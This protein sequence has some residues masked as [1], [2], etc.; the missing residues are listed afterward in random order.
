M[1]V[2]HAPHEFPQLPRQAR[3]FAR[4]RFRP[5]PNLSHRVSSVCLTL[6]TLR[7]S[8]RIPRRCSQSTDFRVVARYNR[9]AYSWIRNRPSRNGVTIKHSNFAVSQRLFEEDLQGLSNLKGDVPEGV[10]LFSP[11]RNKEEGR[12]GRRQSFL[13]S[14][15]ISHVRKLSV[16]IYS[17]LDKDVD[18]TK[19]FQR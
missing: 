12:R 14:H 4:A 7:Q 18:H 15:D 1:Y 10:S 9:A 19:E 16:I 11:D 5:S 3:S 2:P 8:R 6:L 13:K 17:R